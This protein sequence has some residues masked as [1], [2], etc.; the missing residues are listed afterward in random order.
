MIFAKFLVMS[1]GAF[2][3]LVKAIE[4][5]YRYQIKEYRF[6]RMGSY[7]REEGWNSVLYGVRYG[8]PARTA[9]NVILAGTSFGVAVIGAALTYALPWPVM[10]F[11]FLLNPILALATV[12]A[13][14]GLTQLPADWHRRRIIARATRKL[15]GSSVKI[16]AV[17]GS[18]GKSSVK[19][20]LYEVLK[21]DFAVAKTDKNMNTDVGVAL[22]LL[23][24]LN[25][26]TE[27]FI[28]E[29]GAY[30]TGEIA[31]IC[32]FAPPT[33]VIVTAF[34]NQHVDLY[35]SRE[36][37]VEAE[38]EPL[39]FMANNGRAYINKDIPEYEPLV[40]KLRPSHT[41]Y[42][43]NTEKADITAS[44]IVSDHRGTR[45]T[46]RYRGR[47]HRLH[48][49]L[50]G[51]HSVANILPVIA[52]ATDRGMEMK[53]VL[54]TLR[55][56][57]PVKHKLS[58]HE[59]PRNSVVISDSANS[60]VNGFLEA[61]RVL[62]TFPQKRK[63]MVS[64]GIIELGKEKEASYR[65]LVQELVSSRTPLLTTDP[66][67]ARI[68]EATDLISLYENEEQLKET[69]DRELGS[70]TVVLLEGR[71]TE[72]FAKRYIGKPLSP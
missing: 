72:G 69:I 59:G 64:K 22:S 52:F 66:L 31:R 60:N 37:L 17:T 40:R 5:V 38:S 28:A 53:T 6:D 18:Y 13:L 34:G 7:I 49:P 51:R 15:A 19:E 54:D 10:L 57:T 33:Y 36:A 25:G 29:M 42:A 9:R 27:Y 3:F 26:D 32:S 24:H 48:T 56:V 47:T 23:K 70:D 1:A 12:S 11:A 35:G 63:I 39:L 20:L 41:H 62:A 43:L 46:I 44:E 21:R 50:L 8:I 2:F 14:V 45:A 71:F 55:H 4:F 65:R 61:I 16:I 67:F 58:L 68:G 30:R